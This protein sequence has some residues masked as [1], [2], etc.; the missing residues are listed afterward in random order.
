MASKYIDVVV[1]GIRTLTPRIREYLLAAADGRPLPRY[2]P[3]AHVALHMVSDTRGPIVRHYSLIGG[4]A[5]EDDPR[6]VYRIAV[7]REDRARGSAFIHDTFEPG[8]RLR[9]SPP[10]N[11]FPLD[12]RDAS[13]LLIAG[14]IGVTPIV[15]MTRSLARRGC[16]YS[17]VYAGRN[18]A[19][20]AYRDT[21]ARLAGDRVRFHHSD[22][23]GVLD[24]RGLLASQPEDTRAYVCGPAPMIAA[25]RQAGADLGW[26]PDRVRSELF[27]AGPA[28]D[29]TAFEVE[30]RRSGKLV[31]VGPDAS[32]LDALRLADVPV[33]WDCARGE[34]GLCPLPVVSAD[35]PI[36]HR[37]RYLSEEERAAGHTLCICVSRLRGTRLVL[38][39]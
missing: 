18:A 20:M 35:G 13:T 24:L 7:Q 4:L 16:R 22:E 12:R 32:I 15:S 19:S 5:G 26:E 6:H 2:E 14:G 33:L 30:L 8:T 28:S 10:V 37:D 9:I 3:G 36:D 25:A 34:C 29:E 39:A 31:Q 1:A 27:A 23:E 17:V 38:D 11:D 21:L